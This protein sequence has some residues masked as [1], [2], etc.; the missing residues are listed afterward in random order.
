MFGPSRILVLYE[1]NPVRSFGKRWA[2]SL[3]RCKGRYP[4]GQFIRIV[5]I[6]WNRVEG[7]AVALCSTFKIP[8]HVRELD[9]LPDKGAIVLLDHDAAYAEWAPAESNTFV[10]RECIC[11]IDGQVGVRAAEKQEKV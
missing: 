9:W 1:P 6:V 7:Y 5:R 2:P 8:P 11:A 10:R 4:V 3:D